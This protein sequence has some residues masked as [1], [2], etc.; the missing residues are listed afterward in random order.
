MLDLAEELHRWTEEGRAFA[1]ATVVA[2]GGS[3]PRGP[4]AAL[5]VDS[6][7]TVIGSVSGGCVEGA[8]Y[9]LCVRALED[10]ETVVE[11]FGYSDED[12]FAVGLTCG[13]IIDIMVTPVGTDAPARPVLRSALSAAARGEPAAVARVVRGPAELLGTAVL[14]RPG[15]PRGASP[16]RSPGR[17]RTKAGSAG[18]R[19]WT[20]RP[21]VKP[22]LCW[23][24]AAPAR[25]SC[26]RTARAAPAG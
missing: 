8:V 14:V 15:D 4:G 22:A 16:G 10:G 20:V 21:P 11:R 18:R 7:G 5:A 6:E 13:G 17:A 12:A 9:D 23:T 1:V 24:P 2:V 25:S 19:S 26:R 3:A